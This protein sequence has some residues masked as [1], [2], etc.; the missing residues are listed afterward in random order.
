MLC[1][2]TVRDFKVTTEE[3]VVLCR[4]SKQSIL[5]YRNKLLP[6]LAR[7]QNLSPNTIFLAKWTLSQIMRESL[8][9][10]MFL[11]LMLFMHSIFCRSLIVSKRY[12]Y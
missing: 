9:Q 1:M 11:S 10:P 8:S 6:Y 4:I 12:L 7:V 3:I 5:F 2:K